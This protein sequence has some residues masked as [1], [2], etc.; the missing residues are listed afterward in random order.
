M[1]S[2]TRWRAAHAGCQ[3]SGSSAGVSPAAMSLDPQPGE[4]H[5]NGFLAL[6]VFASGW[7]CARSPIRPSSATSRSC[8]SRWMRPTSTS[9]D[10]LV[11]GLGLA[12]PL[13]RRRRARRSRQGRRAGPTRSRSSHRC[14]FYAR[15]MGGATGLSGQPHD[16]RALFEDPVL[17]HDGNGRGSSRAQ[18][19]PGRSEI[20]GQLLRPNSMARAPVARHTPTPARGAKAPW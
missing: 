10:G 18:G 11:N 9:A 15:R 19:G 17:A 13:D 8:R 20:P 4:D 12:A 1:A 7:G 6:A 14:P 2:K 5:R 3:S 16:I